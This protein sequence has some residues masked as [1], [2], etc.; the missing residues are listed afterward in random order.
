MEKD[1]GYSSGDDEPGFRSSMILNSSNLSFGDDVN[2][3]KKDKTCN[4]C[5]NSFAVIG[6][7][8]KHYCKFCFRGVHASCSKHKAPDRTGKNV[9]ICDRCYQ[10]AIQDQ[11]KDN[12]QK[13][14]DKVN[15]ELEE[16]KKNMNTERDQ[17]KYESYRRDGLERKLEEMKEENIR[18]EKEFNDQSERLKKELKTMEEDIEE[19]TRILASA[20]LEKRQRDEKIAV[21]KQ[22][23]NYLQND[24][25]SDIDKITD[26]KRLIEEQENENESLIKELNSHTDISGENEDP[27]SRAN[28]LD[29]LKQKVSHAKDAQKDLKKENENLKKRLASL[30]EENASKKAEITK[31][32]EGGMQ[33]KRSMS[34]M[35]A[36]IKELETQIEFQEQEITRLQE[37]LNNSRTLK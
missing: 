3:Y 25:Q 5:S 14:L 22:E 21:L 6:S 10:K 35:T 24:T 12:L 13:E 9:R 33:R 7:S 23:I 27:L 11:V 34:K 20:D 17:R 19:L 8:K 4:V 15:V 29:N 30:R 2:A 1:E 37:K 26:L 18:K 31:F 36:D 16:I 32:E 28:L